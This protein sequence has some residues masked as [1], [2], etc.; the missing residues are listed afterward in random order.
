MLKIKR[1][2]LHCNHNTFNLIRHTNLFLIAGNRPV[3]KTLTAFQ[4]VQFLQDWFIF[5][6]Q[7]NSSQDL[8]SSNVFSVSNKQNSVWYSVPQIKLN[9]VSLLCPRQ[10]TIYGL[11]SVPQTEHN[12][13]CLQCLTDKT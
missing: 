9:L 5:C 4:V 13:L 12:L 11:F 8:V 2:I 7:I 3:R 10:N 1:E 6:K